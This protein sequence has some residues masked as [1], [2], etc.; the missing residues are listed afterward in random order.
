MNMLHQNKISVNEVDTASNTY[1]T[2]IEQFPEKVRGSVASRRD[3]TGKS[4]K[5]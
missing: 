4:L 2:G 1:K 5:E 3:Y